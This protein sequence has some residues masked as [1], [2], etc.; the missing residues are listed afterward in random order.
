MRGGCAD[1]AAE[2][3][4]EDYTNLVLFFG[5]ESGNRVNANSTLAVDFFA[6]LKEAAYENAN[7]RVTLP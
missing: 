3:D 4:D 2:E 7:G 5:C 1:Q 6:K